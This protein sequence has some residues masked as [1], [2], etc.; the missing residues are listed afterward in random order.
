M[1]REI[2][3]GCQ[4][5]RRREMRVRFS[6]GT[7]LSRAR[8]LYQ[9]IGAPSVHTALLYGAHLGARETNAMNDDATQQMRQHRESN[10]FSSR[11]LLCGE[12]VARNGEGDERLGLNRILNIW[13]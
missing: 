13:C 2:G 4:A 11:A 8:R 3:H 5:M 1:E 12:I 6:V 10:E 7:M 9:E